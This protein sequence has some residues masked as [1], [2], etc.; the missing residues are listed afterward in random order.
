MKILLIILAFILGS[1]SEIENLKNNIYVEGNYWHF[2]LETHDKTGD[3]VKLYT[4]IDKEE[5]SRK[6]ELIIKWQYYSSFYPNGNPE[7]EYVAASEV[8]I[9]KIELSTPSLTDE[10]FWSLL[11]RLQIDK[12]LKA[13][14]SDEKTFSIKK[15]ETSSKSYDEEGNLIDDVDNA[16]SEPQKIE[17]P[18]EL[19]YLGKSFSSN[20]VVNDSCEHY[21]ISFTYNVDGDKY[22][23]AKFLY[24]YYFHEKYGFVYIKINV[25]NSEFYEM[26]L[27]EMKL[28]KE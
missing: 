21:Q 12:S 16:K 20:P 27:K 4:K 23:G 6:G 17:Y 2:A 11:P 25:G 9:L 10:Q 13:N 24:D 22:N 28:K 18:Y 5:N 1:C 26:N 3:S 19:K 8:S 15:W 7:R 14:E